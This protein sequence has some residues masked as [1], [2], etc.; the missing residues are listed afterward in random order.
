M[1]PYNV[2]HRS[3]FLIASSAFIA[4]QALGQAPV[5]PAPKPDKSNPASIPTLPSAPSA[6]KFDLPVTTPEST[7][8]A[9][10]A[11]EMLVMSQEPVQIFDFNEIKNTP[12]DAKIL[13]SEEKDGIIIEHLQYTSRSTGGRTETMQGI[14]AYPKGAKKL[15]AVFWSQ[16][17][18]SAASEY[19]PVLFAKKG[20][21]CLN[22]TLDHKL[23]NAWAPFDTNLPS[24]A[25]LTLLARDQMRGITLLTQRPEVDP[26]MIGVGGSSYGGF[27]ANVI[28]AND[29]RVKAGFSYFSGANHALGTNL[30]QFT[31]LKTRE[32]IEIFNSTIDPAAKLSKL[33]IPFLWAIAF[34]DHWF[35]FPA[36]TKAFSD[37]PADQEKRLIVAGNWKHGFPESIDNQLNNFLDT[38]LTRTAPP[39]LDPGK[40][41]VK[42]DPDG[43][44]TASFDVKGARPIKRA[45]ILVSPG[46]A[47]NWIGWSL[48]ASTNI[49]ATVSGTSI[50]ATVPIPSMTT[51][52][53]LV[54]QVYDDQGNLTSTAPVIFTFPITDRSKKPPDPKWTFNTFATDD[55]SKKSIDFW[56]ALGYPPATF[57]PDVKSG[58]RPT[59]RLPKDKDPITKEQVM[60]PIY[61]VPG[62]AHNLSLTLKSEKPQLIEVVMRPLPP[63]NWQSE[64]VR[65]QVLDKEA[66]KK[67][68]PKPA[69]LIFKAETTAEFKEFTFKVPA[70]NWPIEGYELILRNPAKDGSKYWLDTIKM[71]PIWE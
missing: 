25:N 17:G 67:Y 30:P 29:P 59:L 16:G 10:M 5:L 39:Y 71:Q 65:S 58:D 3:L 42:A 19:F 54:G 8:A 21:V 48:R 52:Y 27:F 68:N 41:T 62:Q 40:L 64:G 33:K 32:E 46:K 36:A 51:S 45:E 34:D 1:S 9:N 37:S 50:K 14:M 53:V 44:L 60:P 35:H 4:T 7:E 28:A 43:R 20:Y 18:M 13:K 49:P 61:N 57:D 38:S 11:R 26:N 63:Q 12:L 47:V 55:F 15:P 2:I 70:D 24:E 22:I 69:D 66:L 23:R 56:T 31:G 6:P